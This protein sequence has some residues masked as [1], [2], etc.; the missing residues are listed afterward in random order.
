MNIKNKIFIACLFLITGIACKK[1]IIENLPYDL[2]TDKAYVRF[3]LFSPGTTAVL[4]KVNDIKING[5]NTGGNGGIY[6]SISNTPD[7]AA[8]P[9]TGNFR[10]S[11]AN[12]GTSND[13]VLIFNSQ[14]A[15]QAGKFYAVTLADTGIDRTVFSVP[16]NLGPL[17]D[18]GFF[19]LR[20]INAMAKT[21]PLNLIR[22]DSTSATS[23]VRDTIARNIAFKSASNFIKLSIS[24]LPISP[25]APSVLYSFLR[26]RIATVSGVP[27]ANV[28]P[29]API[30][31]NQR[32]VTTYA[33]G[34]GNGTL[35]YS[36]G[37]SNFIY[38][39]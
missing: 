18:S 4:I 34:F 16:D 1:N 23:V 22:I 28:T 30:S 31:L 5:S 29:P 24:P 33:F 21:E 12:S 17:P 11:L 8:V 10:L 39:Q 15:V 13:S 38:N 36:P 14:I 27:L 37:L 9:T 26:F 20:L 25:S 32:S 3:A 19:N 7:Y 35:I 2:P 6:P